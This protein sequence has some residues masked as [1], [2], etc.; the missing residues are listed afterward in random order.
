MSTDIANNKGITLSERVYSKKEPNI[1][2]DKN[3]NTKVEN[4]EI[5]NSKGGSKL[6]A[7]I[8]AKPILFTLIVVGTCAV[9]KVAIVVPVVLVNKNNNDSKTNDNSNSHNN[10]NIGNNFNGNNNG[11]NNDNNNHN[12]NHNNNNENN[13]N[14]DGNINNERLFDFSSININDK[15]NAIGNDISSSLDSFCTHLNGISSSLNNKEKI[16]LIYQ[17]VTKNIKYDYA[18][19]TSEAVLDCSPSNVLTTKKTVCSGYSRL[20]TELLKC[21]NYPS[22]NILNI[23]GHSKGLGYNIE[24]E[25]TDDNTDHEWNAVKLEDE[26]CL[27]DTTWGAGSIENGAFK[28][29]YTE[30]YL[31]TPPEQFVRTHLPKTTEEQYQFL[32]NPINANTFKELA[33]TKNL[34]FEYGFISIE[35]DK[36]IQ[37]FCGDGQITLRYE[38]ETRPLLLLKVEKDE[39]E[40]KWAMEEKIS[41]GYN[42]NFYIN[43]V[44]TYNLDI[45][46]KINRDESINYYGI[47][48]FKI[49]CNSAP[50]IKRYYPKVT[51]D[52]KLDDSIK[53]VSPIDNEL[54]R[55]ETYNF[56][57]E[58]SNHD[59]LYLLLIKDDIKEIIVMDKEGILFIENNVM[60][61]GENVKISYKSGNQY[62]PLVEYTTKGEN[63]DF[64]STSETPFKKRLER[65]LQSNL[66]T[67]ETY[68]IKIICDTTYTIKLFDN[69]NNYSDFTQEGNIYTKSITIETGISQYKAMYG[70]VDSEGHYY[71]MYTFT[72]SS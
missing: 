7:F 36:A 60:V 71:P 40:F 51:Y 13:N 4:I 10:E 56:K 49:Y 70:P 50:E 61:H 57:I 19:Y 25:L 29:S 62:K 30:Y 72:V 45:K 54:T 9:V 32:E 69:N 8:K 1:V 26:W 39:T 18:A 64:P 52:Y 37:N 59:K 22:D 68:E 21:L 28:P 31:C 38:G 20:F 55:G 58:S 35:N 41:N 2:D 42:I 23:I 48:N 44:G 17:W 53:L 5:P 63:I 6:L 47:V 65:P 34:F 66:I 43:E 3:L 67:G 33:P 46:A 14:N 16:Y 27:I 15:Y 11:N 24:T 12:N